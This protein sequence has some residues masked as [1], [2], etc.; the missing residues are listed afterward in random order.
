MTLDIY[1]P[2]DTKSETKMPKLIKKF[3]LKKPNYGEVIS[4]RS[5]KKYSSEYE[6][7]KKERPNE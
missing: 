4:P 1:C 6:M 2:T 7:I 5:G 3:R